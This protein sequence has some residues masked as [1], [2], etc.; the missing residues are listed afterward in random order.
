MDV[1]QDVSVVSLL[2][3]VAEIVGLVPPPALR[4]SATVGG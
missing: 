4:L 2:F 3:V 1:S